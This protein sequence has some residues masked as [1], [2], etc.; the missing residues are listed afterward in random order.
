MKAEKEVMR[1]KEISRGKN[2]IKGIISFESSKDSIE[3]LVAKDLKERALKGI[4]KYGHP[5][6]ESKDDMLQHLYEE[7]L[8]AASYIKM[9]KI[10]QKDST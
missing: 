1:F 2:Y 7:L 6:H 3:D 10:Q 8:D 4:Q 9:L 5:L